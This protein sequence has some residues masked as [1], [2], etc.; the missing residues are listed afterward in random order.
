MVFCQYKISIFYQYKISIF[1]VKFWGQYYSLCDT[2]NTIFYGLSYL[3]IIIIDI[4]AW[5]LWIHTTQFGL[6]C[7]CMCFISLVVAGFR[8]PLT[9]DD[10]WS[11]NPE[12][13]CRQVYPQFEK[14]WLK[15]INKCSRWTLNT[16]IFCCLIYM[17]MFLCYISA[18]FL[19]LAYLFIV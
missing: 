6:N 11:L 5:V 17:Q 19:C 12:D 10:L 16:C 8:H 14:Q 1:Y 7:Q 13:T 4:F 2:D 15:E 3:S 18:L 9:R